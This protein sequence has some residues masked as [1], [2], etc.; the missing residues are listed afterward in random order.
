MWRFIDLDSALQYTD[1]FMEPI[2]LLNG[3]V[4]HVANNTTKNTVLR[5]VNILRDVTFGKVSLLVRRMTSVSLL[6]R[7][8]SLLINN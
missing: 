6:K 7:F 8:D 3:R 2:L 4:L 1:S 5:I